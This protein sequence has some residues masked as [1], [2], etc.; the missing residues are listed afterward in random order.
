MVFAVTAVIGAG[1]Y[2]TAYKLLQQKFDQNYSAAKI[3][4]FKLFLDGVVIDHFYTNNFKLDRVYFH[5][6]PWKL[7]KA[8]PDYI[9]VLSAEITNQNL[10]T[11]AI[12]WPISKDIPLV[13]ERLH[14]KFSLLNKNV[15]VTGMAKQDPETPL[16]VDFETTSDTLALQGQAEIRIHDNRMQMIDLEF[17]DAF[18]GLKDLQ[19]KRM[20]GWLS[21]SYENDWQVIGEMEAGFTGFTDRNFSEASL[22]INGPAMAPDVTFSATEN[23]R[24]VEINR[25]DG[26]VTLQK[27]ARLFPVSGNV[28]DSALLQNISVTLAKHEQLEMAELLQQQEKDQ[29]ESLKKETIQP[30]QEPVIAI[31]ETL[32]EKPVIPV[33]PE[34][35]RLP[36]IR[37]AEL[38]GN[39]VL[40]G[41]VYSHSVTPVKHLEGTWIARGKG[42]IVTYDDRNIPEYFIKLKD[43]EQSKVLQAALLNFNV[44]SLTVKGVGDQV[45]EMILKGTTSAN[46]PAEIQLSVLALE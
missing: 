19:T 13:I 41:F 44:R 24:V 20:S 29:L 23:N 12:E 9:N 45:Q 30:V 46:Q 31:I 32:P 5:G 39:S 2:G 37:L 11:S 18:I 22:K 17:Q 38:L 35:V 21:Y 26:V 15:A 4:G 6:T 7:Y 34:P 1:M 3:D 16:L 40:R 33:R 42:G 14:F 27:D 10:F 25:K 43:Y 8:G 36:E 28:L